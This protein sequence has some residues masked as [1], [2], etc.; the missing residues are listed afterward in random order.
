MAELPNYLK[1][2]VICALSTGLRLSNVLNIKWESIDFENN[3]IEILKQDNKGHIKIQLP[4]SNKFKLVLDEIGIKQEGYIFISHRTKTKFKK[5]NNGFKEAC[6]RA[7][8][9][10]F[11]FHDLRHTVATRLVAKG[12]DLGTVREYLGHSSLAMTQRYSHP[13]PE[14]MQSC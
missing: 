9:K 1:P 7:G 11:R 12:A 13:T 10:N 2:I 4:I 14:N 8:I 3:F 6:N 5:I